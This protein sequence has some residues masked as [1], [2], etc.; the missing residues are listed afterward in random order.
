MKNKIEQVAKILK[1]QYADFDHYNKKNPLNELLFIICSVQTNQR[2]YNSSYLKLK[3]KYPSFGELSNADMSDLQSILEPSGLSKQKSSAILE[4]IQMLSDRFGKATL[5][6]IKKMLLEDCEKFLISLP[7]VG[8][9]VARCIMLYSLSHRVFPVDTH[10][11]RIVK[12]LGW[13]KASRSDGRYT[14]REVD[15]IQEMI[16]E[17]LRYS[18]HVNMVSLGRDT[19]LNNPRCTKCCLN[20]LCPKIDVTKDQLQ[21]V[22]DQL[23]F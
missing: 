13:I 16:P 10:C 4:I 23:T 8:K 3:R 11:W 20:K 5:A 6:P 14:D 2:S 17:N 1:N 18:L 7:R 12:R 22:N 21:N 15:L 19:C 9:K